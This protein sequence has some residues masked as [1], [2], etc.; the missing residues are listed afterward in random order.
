MRP[1]LTVILAMSPIAQAKFW[2]EVED[3]LLL[4]IDLGIGCGVTESDPVR[5]EAACRLER[6][7][8]VVVK[9]VGPGGAPTR[10]TVNRV[11]PLSPAKRRGSSPLALEAKS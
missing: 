4:D 3:E 6:A 1:R 11:F 10:V 5:I 7:G 9:P 2:A 8:I